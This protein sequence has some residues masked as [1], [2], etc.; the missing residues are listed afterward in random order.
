MRALVEHQPRRLDG[1]GQALHAGNASGAQVF[2]VHQQCV[3]LHASVA[4]QK[5][6]ATRIEGLVVFHNRDRS[7]D[8]RDRAAALFEYRI[9]SIERA[10]DPA[11]MGADFVVR[12]GPG[13]AVNQKDGL[14]HQ[15][16]R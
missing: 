2:P 5:R 11:L 3:E 7:L 6:A 13:A 15:H 16:L 14:W 8:R 10:G 4:R 12:H 9:A 1:V